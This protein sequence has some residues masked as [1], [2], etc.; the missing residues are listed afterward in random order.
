MDDVKIQFTRLSDEERPPFDCKDKDLNEFFHVDSKNGSKD[1]ITVT[2]VV[3]ANG[4]LAAFFC[5]SNDS[6]RVEDTTTSKFRKIRSGITP[7]KKFSSMPAVKIGRLATLEKGTGLGTLILDLIKVWFTKGNKTGCRFIIV[8]AR[9]SQKVI[10]FYKR[11]GFDF[12]DT[13]IQIKS[14][15]TRLMFFD[16]FTFVKNADNE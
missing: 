9:N 11:N 2:Y 4:V 12:L 16:L 15:R 7:S 8:D 3:E 5:V 10:N 14:G 6:I 1:L 13:N